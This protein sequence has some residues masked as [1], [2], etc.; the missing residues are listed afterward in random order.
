MFAGT[1]RRICWK[2]GFSNTQAV[3]TGL[4]GSNCRGEE[5]EV[6]FVWSLTSGKKFVLADGHEVHWSKESTFSQTFDSSWQWTWQTSMAGAS[7]ELTVVAHASSPFFDKKKINSRNAS[8][9]D[10]SFRRIDLL[11]DGASFSELPKM[12]QLGRKTK[13]DQARISDA[14]GEINAKERRQK[15]GSDNGIISHSVRPVSM[16]FE[17]QQQKQAPP[18]QHYNFHYPCAAQQQL[19]QHSYQISLA[20]AEDFTAAANPFDMYATSSNFKSHVPHQQ[21]QSQQ[22]HIRQYNNHYSGQSQNQHPTVY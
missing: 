14:R 12:F 17:R 6:V 10:S 18:S 4:S 3:D 16:P 15:L 13:G 22:Q 9:A 8:V 7:R 19:N 5:H 11:V 20:P 21:L 1:K 2:F